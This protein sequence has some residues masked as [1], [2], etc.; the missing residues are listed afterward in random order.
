MTGNSKHPVARSD[1]WLDNATMERWD[2]TF[3]SNDDFRKAITCYIVWDHPCWGVFD[4]DEFCK[5]LSGEPSELASK[6]LV[7]TVL[8]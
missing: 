5:A 7:F 6:V 4:V 3:I 8:S 2:I 1:S